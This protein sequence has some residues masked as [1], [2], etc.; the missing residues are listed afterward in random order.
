MSG[1]NVRWP[2]RMLPTLWRVTVSRLTGQT[3]R[4]TDDRPLHYA[5]HYRLGK[6]NNGWAARSTVPYRANALSPT[7]P[8]PS[9]PNCWHTDVRHRNF[10]M[11]KLTCSLEVDMSW[12]YELLLK[13]T[14][15][16]VDSISP[17]SVWLLHDYNYAKKD[18]L[19]AL[20]QNQYSFAFLDSKKRRRKFHN[21]VKFNAV[22]SVRDGAVI[23]A[24][25][26][27]QKSDVITYETSQHSKLLVF[28]PTTGDQQQL[29]WPTVGGPRTDPDLSNT[30]CP[31]WLRRIEHLQLRY[32]YRINKYVSSS[33]S[34]GNVRWT[35]RVLSPGESRW[36]CAAC[37]IKVRKKSPG[38]LLRLEKRWDRRTFR[39]MLHRYITLTA[40]C[41]Q[42]DN[43][44]WDQ[45]HHVTLTLSILTP[46][47][48][49]ISSICL[50]LQSQY[51][52][53]TQTQ[54]YNPEPL[55]ESAKSHGVETDADAGRESTY[56]QEGQSLRVCN[57]LVMTTMFMTMTMTMTAWMN[58]SA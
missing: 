43:S 28:T 39:R 2:R 46:S 19:I 51:T 4:L 55:S 7:P 22:K 44:G 27:R 47:R 49:K 30:S 53:V 9:P 41:G 6:S 21:L 32:R 42:G 48:Q 38:A 24:E 3:N 45:Q 23:T 17:V 29:R 12:Y 56:R 11:N 13:S 33:F 34:N 14:K 8:S 37:S 25:S 36:V 26:I 52:N 10:V 16:I 31:L 50:D 35:R 1:R 20:F 57:R 58:S 5:F 54:T 40:R 18:V 15:S